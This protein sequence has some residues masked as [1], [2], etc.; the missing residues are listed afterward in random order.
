M[1]LKFKPHSYPVN[2]VELVAD[3]FAGQAYT[4]SIQYHLDPGHVVMGSVQDIAIAGEYKFKN[5]GL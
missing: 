5:A 1:K 4:A 3:C 2:A